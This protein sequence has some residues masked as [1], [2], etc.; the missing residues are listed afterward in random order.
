[1][2]KFYSKMAAA[3]TASSAVVCMCSAFPASAAETVRL[4]GD[5]DGD[6]HV[7]ALDAQMTL[8]LYAQALVGNADNTATEENS[9][10]DID[11][12][13]EID[14]LDAQYILLYYCQTLVGDQPLWA[15]FR[16]VS[17]H[18]G[19][20]WMVIVGNEE[21]RFARV[22]NKDP[23]ELNGLYVEIGCAQGAPGEIVTVP[24]Y[25]AGGDLCAVVMFVDTPEGLELTD[26]TSHVKEDF[27]L[28]C[29]ETPEQYQAEWDGEE[30]R[31]SSL[32]SFYLPK[33][34]GGFTTSEN[35]D[36]KDGYVV[37]YYSYKIP[38]DAQ[39]GTAYPICLNASKCEFCAVNPEQTGCWH[40]EYT[41]LN[42]V[43]VVE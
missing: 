22:P 35:L 7:T 1:M 39:S 34:S 23:F 20:D 37:A 5:L 16:E 41:L 29:P 2:K 12:D 8:D 13:G 10:V 15:D 36:M 31:S 17:Y 42:G 26:I 6:L 33:G 24:V 3:L 19:T 9:N 11:M 25:F 27:N 40:Y 28:W 14:V 4:T 43:V 30:H 21:D 38:E 32:V 18:D